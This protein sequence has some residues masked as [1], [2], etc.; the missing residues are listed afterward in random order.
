LST[1]SYIDNNVQLGVAYYYAVTTVDNTGYENDHFYV[2]GPVVDFGIYIINT[3]LDTA[4]VGTAYS[5][6]LTAQGGVKPYRWKIIRGGLPMG[7][8][9]KDST[10]VISGI[11][12]SDGSSFLTVQV[13]DA[14]QNALSTQKTFTMVVQ[15]TNSIVEEKLIITDETGLLQN[16]PNP[17]TNFT[18]VQF[19]IPV[20]QTVDLSIYNN[21]GKKVK[22]LENK[23]FEAG[24]YSV[25]WNGSNDAG[26]QIDPGLYICVMKS[27]NYVLQRKIILLKV[28]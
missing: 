20:S 26:R 28:N 7:L 4:K 16:Y 2:L 19:A 14:R 5:D 21:L 13:N 22:T 27:G 25:S 8:S 17:F 10:G 15:S 11:P 24:S 23:L 9:L 18:L 1:N 3:V 6:T 12:V